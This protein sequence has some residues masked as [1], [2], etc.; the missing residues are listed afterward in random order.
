M[1]PMILATLIVLA[2]FAQGAAQP[3]PSMPPSDF[4]EA[5][6]FC[7]VMTLCTKAKGAKGS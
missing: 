4:P 7:D 3:M 5:G 2:S 1:R 6:T